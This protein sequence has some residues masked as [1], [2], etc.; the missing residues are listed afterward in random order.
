MRTNNRVFRVVVPCSSEIAGHF[1]GTYPF[2]LQ[3]WRIS[4]NKKQTE[5]VTLPPF[6]CLL[7]AWITLGP[8]RWRR[9]VPQKWRSFAQLH[10]VTTQKNAL[11]RITAVTTSNLTTMDE[12]CNLHGY[13]GRPP[14][15]NRVLRIIPAHEWIISHLKHCRM[16]HHEWFYS[17]LQPWSEQCLSPGPLSQGFLG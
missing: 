8:C 5:A 17:L 2:H 12:V 10:D 6:F 15:G 7:F 3:D 9:Y 13:L 4:Q 14:C 16:S 11:F 1:G